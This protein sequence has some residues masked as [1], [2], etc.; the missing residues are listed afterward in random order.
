MSIILLLRFSGIWFLLFWVGFV[1]QPAKRHAYAQSSDNVFTPV[2]RE[3][4]FDIVRNYTF[5]YS[6]L[7]ICLEPCFA[8]LAMLFPCRICQIMMMSDIAAQVLMFARNAGH[9]WLWQS[10][11]LILPSEVILHHLSWLASKLC[12][13]T[14][15]LCSL[16]LSYCS[17]VNFKLYLM[18]IIESRNNMNLF[19]FFFACGFHLSLTKHIHVL[20]LTRWSSVSK[21]IIWL[22][23]VFQLLTMIS[24]YRWLWFQ[25]YSLGI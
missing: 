9:W 11:L 10:K 16:S 21:E 5:F 23:R 20:L 12:W 15:S 4:I 6:V 19:F 24:A 14:S 1:L 13:E 25:S 2:E 7:S 18:L 17:L 22:L 3:L 8:S